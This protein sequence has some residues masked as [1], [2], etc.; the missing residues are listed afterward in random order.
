MS[1]SA[2]S[3]VINLRL[4]IAGLLAIA[5]GAGAAV[6]PEQALV[7][8][9]TAALAVCLLA[10]IFAEPVVGLAL[11]LFVAPFAPLEN[12]MLNLPVESGQVLLFVTLAAWLARALVRRRMGKV[13]GPLMWPLLA[14]IAVGVLSFFAARSA[15]LWARECLKWI[16]VLA[17]YAMTVNELDTGRRS[18][19]ILIGAILASTLFEAALGSYQFWLRGSGPAS[20]LISGTSHY[21]AY[22]TFEQPNPFGGYMGLTWP[23]A[24]GLAMYMVRRAI[25]QRRAHT[26][27]TRSTIGVIILAAVTAMTAGLSLF[28]LVLSWSR[29]AWLGAAAAGAVMVFILVRRPLQSLAVLTAAVIVVV[30]VGT[31][32]LIPQ[33]LIGRLTDFTREFTSFDVRN[34]T[35][36]SANHA[37]IERLAHWQAAEN[38]I[39]AHPYFGVGFG[40]YTAAYEQYR[41]LNWPLALGHAH[42]YY[43]NVFAEMGI[44]GLVAYIMLWAAVFIRSVQRTQETSTMQ[45]RRL[46]GRGGSASSSVG[47]SAMPLAG[48]V[49]LGLVGSWVQ[50]SVHQ[51]VDNLFVANIPLLIAVFIGLLDGL[52]N[53]PATEDAGI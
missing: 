32:G 16:E 18:R 52:H 27:V 35:V 12:I 37:V 47:I 11:T 26:P 3:A 39:V 4:L 19:N 23:F 17:V 15:D 38:M 21:R 13:S 36:T 1:V 43:L 44:V 53:P 41:T 48:F 24:A 30:A 14:F 40:N 2:R 34:V 10:L 28:A 46:Q 33:S 22:G 51:V 29:G 42:N 50:L 6:L 7:L 49:A 31:M 20:F 8:V 5:A 9:I 25:A 45:D